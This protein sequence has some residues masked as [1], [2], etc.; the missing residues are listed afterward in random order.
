MP[1]NVKM[2]LIKDPIK[3][4]TSNKRKSNHLL[5]RALDGRPLRAMTELKKIPEFDPM[6]LSAKNP[7]PLD[8][9]IKFVEETHVYYVKFHTGNFSCEHVLSTSGFVGNYFSHFN[10]DLIVSKMGQRT[11]NTKYKGMTNDQI[12][13]AWQKNGEQ[14]S[15]IGTNFH[16][17]LESYYNGMDL[18]PY[19]DYG[20]V[21]QFRRW[22]EKHVVPQKLVPFR[23][24][25]RMRTDLKTRL[26]GT[27]DMLFALAVQDPASGVLKLVMRDW[28]FS[29][30][31]KFSSPFPGT[32]GCCSHLDN[33][34]FNKYL[35]QQNVYKYMLE[36]F[37]TNWKYQGHVYER[38]EVVDMALAVF[39]DSQDDF[40][41]INLTSI[42]PLI[43]EMFLDREQQLKYLLTGDE[44]KS[45]EVIMG[46][47]TKPDVF[48][49]SP[50]REQKIDSQILLIPADDE[51]DDDNVPLEPFA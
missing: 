5:F 42:Q 38:V 13:A 46:V 15:A 7:H 44:K 1:A 26:T 31:I 14:A 40:Q 33:C 22:H 18:T 29:K 19:D 41:H 11:R 4:L 51:D 50:K 30:E 36:R 25:Q 28:K 23:S 3:Q 39:H 48:S 16:F 12:K 24:E 2:M 17:L 45:E 47:I 32:Y 21:Q 35:L 49:S 27:A 43:E 37:Y 20:V 8:M 9:T 6:F 10:A 34:N